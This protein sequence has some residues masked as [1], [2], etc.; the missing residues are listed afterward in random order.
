MKLSLV[1]SWNHLKPTS[2]LDQVKLQKCKPSSE[3]PQT[4]L[5]D[6]PSRGDAWSRPR[7]PNM[8]G[9][10]PQNHPSQCSPS[11]YVPIIALP[12]PTRSASVSFL[13]RF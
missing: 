11:D 4:V 12:L 9:V 10:T 3:G 8:G 7:C 13:E 1:V 6:A 2:M 5:A